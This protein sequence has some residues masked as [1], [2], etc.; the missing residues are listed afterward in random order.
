MQHATKQKHVQLVMQH[1]CNINIKIIA[2]QTVKRLKI[3]TKDATNLQNSN[4]NVQQR[5]NNQV[6]HTD[7]DSIED[8]V[9]N[10]REKN[11]KEAEMNLI[12]WFLSSEGL[13]KKSFQLKRGVQV[14]NPDKFYESLHNEIN[15]GPSGPRALFG[16]LQDDLLCLKK[17]A[18]ANHECK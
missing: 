7:L 3:A 10:G 5:I 6:A 15:I 11:W 8:F 13:P 2:E 16:S 17:I 12:D 9:K 14:N 4:F 18:K 1:K